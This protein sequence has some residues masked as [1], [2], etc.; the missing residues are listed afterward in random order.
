MADVSFRSIIAMTDP[1]RI[2]SCLSKVYLQVLFVLAS[3]V[4]LLLLVLG[5]LH[6]LQ[7]MI[8]LQV[9][10]DHRMAGLVI[11]VVVWGSVDQHGK[12]LVQKGFDHGMGYE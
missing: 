8:R 12:Q 2:N 3:Q 1:L 10:L 6:V 7:A 11:S 4:F 5:S 9:V